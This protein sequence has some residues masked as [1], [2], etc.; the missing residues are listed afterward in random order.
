VIVERERVSELI[1]HLKRTSEGLLRTANQL[2][3]LSM[4][5]SESEDRWVAALD[6][7]IGMAIE[8][9]AMERI[10]HTL[11]DAEAHAPELVQRAG[12]TMA[13]LRMR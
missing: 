9:G 11:D 1:G 2:A 10:L 7:L 5:E 3:A 8:L 12:G 4:E 13:Y 6:D